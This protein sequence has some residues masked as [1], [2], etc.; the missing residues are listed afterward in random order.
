MA[1]QLRDAASLVH[2]LGLVH[3]DVKPENIMVLADGTL[4]LF[5]FG[6]AWMQ[7]QAP[8]PAG[9]PWYMPPEGASCLR[10]VRPESNCADDGVAVDPGT[11]WWAWGVL[12]YWAT[13]NQHPFCQRCPTDVIEGRA[14]EREGDTRFEW[15][16]RNVLTEGAMT[17]TSTLFHSPSDTQQP[18]ASLPLG[19]GGVSTQ[20]RQ[21]ILGVQQPRIQGRN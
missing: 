20:L 16:R 9:T 4:V 12:L 10:V 15:I 14:V 3:R 6:L 2:E 8:S 1:S 17:V 11:D 18:S 19:P 5:D 7:G 21:R 13:F